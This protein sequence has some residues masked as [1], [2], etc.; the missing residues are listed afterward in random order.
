MRRHRAISSEIQSWLCLTRVRTFNSCREIADEF[1]LLQDV[2]HDMIERPDLSRVAQNRTV[3]DHGELFV[4][5]Q[6]VELAPSAGRYLEIRIS[7]VEP[8]EIDGGSFR[9]RRIPQGEYHLDPA[10]QEIL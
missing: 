3:A 6:V 9:L 10:R 2:S 5:N 7:L 1:G 4:A 8:F